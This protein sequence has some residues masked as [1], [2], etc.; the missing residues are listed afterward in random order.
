MLKVNTLIIIPGLF[1]CL[2]AGNSALA[3]DGATLYK[4]KTCIACHGPGG[5][6]PAMSE[7]PKLAGQNEAY[8]L[9]QMKD[10][11]NEARSNSHA[12]PMKNVMHLT[13]EEEM[14]VIAKWLA[15]LK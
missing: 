5:N 15:G 1:L 4:E 7:Y 13:S 8:L 6:S 14:A 2:T 12:A 10:I 3:M 11:K 9:S